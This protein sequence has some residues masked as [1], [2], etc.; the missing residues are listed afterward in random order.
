MN[1]QKKQLLDQF[2]NELW[3]SI[4]NRISLNPILNS[5]QFTVNNYNIDVNLIKS[6]MKSMRMDL[7]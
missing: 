3:L 2:E 7:D 6:F 5:F 4:E 1:I